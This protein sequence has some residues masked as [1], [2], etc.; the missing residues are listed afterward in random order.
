[1]KF[2]PNFFRKA[3]LQK[4]FLCFPDP[5][6]KARKHKARIVS[7]TLCAEYAFVLRVGGKV[8]VVTDVEDLFGWM[9]RCFGGCAGF[10]RVGEGEVE[11]DEGVAVMRGETEEG[12][13]VERNGGG[14]FVA[15]FRRVEDPGWVD[16]FG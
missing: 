11:G 8:Y 14:K 5:H 12:R 6:F 2:L 7:P 3:Q 16:F 10:E 4:I 1:M 15:V 13:K 9:V